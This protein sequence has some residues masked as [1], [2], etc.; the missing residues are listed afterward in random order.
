MLELVFDEERLLENLGLGRRSP[1][2][3]SPKRRPCVADQIMIVF[4]HSD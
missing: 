3:V 2:K 1:I 4:K